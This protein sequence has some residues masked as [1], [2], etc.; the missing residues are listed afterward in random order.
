VKL[1]LLI[2]VLMLATMTLAQ[3]AARAEAKA[4][5][6]AASSSSSSSSTAP[7]V[8]RVCSDP[9][10]LPFSNDRGE[11]FENQLAQSFAAEL[12]ATMETTWWAQRRGFLRNTLLAGRCDVVMGVPASLAKR[13]AHALVLE[14]VT[15]ERD[16]A[17]P[18]A[19]D[20]ALGVRP[21]D[22]AL[23]RE[24]DEALTR[25]RADVDRLLDTFGVP[26]A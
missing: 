6:K 2:L 24:L 3:Q 13:A 22:E 17:F 16:G 12:H 25:R 20:I 21:D 4:K 8:L 7:R 18:M 1:R 19:F 26:H 15:P 14:R 10:N 5:A 11:G 9:N 23:Q